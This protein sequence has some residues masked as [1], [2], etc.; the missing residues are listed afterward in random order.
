MQVGR[1]G[2]HRRRRPASGEELGVGRERDRLDL[3]AQQRQ[4]AAVHLLEVA[5]VDP[6][7]LAAGRERAG[8]RRRRRAPP[9]PRR[10]GSAQA[11]ARGQLAERGRTGVAEPAAQDRRRV[12][13]QRARTRP[14]AR[15]GPSGPGR[16]AR[17]TIRPAPASAAI[18]SASG[19]RPAALGDLARREVAE[20]EEDLGQLLGRA[21]ARLRRGVGDAGGHLGDR[22][23]LEQLGQRAVLQQLGQQRPVERELRR[24]AAR[25]A[26]RRTRRRT[27]SRSGRSSATA[28]GEGSSDS[29][30]TTRISPRSIALEHVGQAV[31]VHH[32]AQAVAVGLEHDREVVEAARPPASGLSP[33]GARARAACACRPR[34]RGSS[35]ARAAFMR[36]WA[37]KTAEPGRSA[38]SRSFA[39]AARHLAATDVDRRLG[40]GVVEAE[41]EAVVAGVDLRLD[42]QPLADRAGQR[43]SPR[44]R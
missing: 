24:A 30:T 40:L 2:R 4:R 36:N 14:A 9:A 21:G 27:A 8:E 34:S 37:L 5:A 33:S 23:R 39:S 1:L 42:A 6:L 25:R 28:T 29:W 17:S 15:R 22:L 7:L 16:R 43:R 11:V 10:P 26:A 3:A 20:L 13:G 44:G 18:Q 35:S 19:R 31:E 12:V 32:V 38:S 41:Q